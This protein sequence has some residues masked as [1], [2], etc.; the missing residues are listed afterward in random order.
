M[1]LSRCERNEIWKIKSFNALLEAS[2]VIRIRDHTFE[3]K[4]SEMNLNKIE[5]FF[6]ILII[7][8]E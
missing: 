5:M 4:S 6:F 8:L 1:H 3:T 7:L 2:N